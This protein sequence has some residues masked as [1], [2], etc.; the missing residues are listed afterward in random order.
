MALAHFP[1][2]WNHPNE[3]NSRQI[4]APEQGAI[5]AH[6]QWG[7][8]ASLMAEVIVGVAMAAFMPVAFKVPGQT[9]IHPGCL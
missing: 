5:C 3:R 9:G 2:G 6:V 1:F 4:N 8:M 7:G